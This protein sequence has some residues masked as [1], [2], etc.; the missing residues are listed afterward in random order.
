MLEKLWFLQKA[1]YQELINDK[2][3]TDLAQKIYNNP[4]D[5]FII[6][7]VIF[8]F[9]EISY[10]TTKTNKNLSVKLVFKICSD[11][12]TN[13]NLLKIAMIIEQ[14]LPSI[15]FKKYNLNLSLIKIINVKFEK[16]DNKHNLILNFSIIV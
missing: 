1:I 16:I 5:N 7:C 9:E 15:N 8:N 2:E 12:Q 14:L 10:I 4:T 3:L 6:P 11:E 13:Q